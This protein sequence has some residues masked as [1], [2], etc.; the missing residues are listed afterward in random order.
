MPIFRCQLTCRD[1]GM[2]DYLWCVP[3]SRSF[4]LLLDTGRP[5]E[6]F[7]KCFATLNFMKVMLEVGT[8]WKVCF[9]VKNV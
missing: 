1:C 4:Q 9:D 7:Q 8:N 3:V 6:T 5:V 2:V